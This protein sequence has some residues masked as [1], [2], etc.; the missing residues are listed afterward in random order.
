MAAKVKF[1]RGA[2][3]VFT[4]HQGKRKKR[5]IGPTKSNKREAEKIA[6]MINARIALGTMGIADERPPSLP[7]T[8]RHLTH[9]ELL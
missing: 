2:W 8:M 5:R 6:H 7:T 3:W 4:H 1:D 9:P